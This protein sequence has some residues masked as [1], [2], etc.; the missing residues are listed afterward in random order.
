ME[1]DYNGLNVLLGLSAGINSAGVY[2]WLK[3]SGMMPAELHLYYAHF[4]EHSPDSFQFVADIIRDARKHF[5]CVKVKITSNSVLRFFEEQK[6]I[7]HPSSSPCSRQLKIEPMSL[8][9]SLNAIQVDL[10]GYV[11]TEMSRIKR[12]NVNGGGTDL[13]LA[14]HFPIQLQDD[15]WC[16]E[17]VKKH[18]GWYP[19][20]YDIR[21]AQGKRIFKHNNCLPCKNM[22]IEQM[23]EVEKYYHEYMVWAK[24]LS[25][26]LKA[27]WG[28]DEDEYYT[29]FG[30][31]DYE[32][33]QCETCQFD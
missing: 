16:F 8:Y 10:I 24:K 23:Q 18:I 17:I 13:F 19:R 4:A 31:Q 26:K 20:I 12:M 5:P 11:R 27:Y 14:K 3:E 25:D 15:E 28:R 7:P 21:N 1:Q 2:C 22:T 9:A 6:M 29:T 32:P 33:E 30:K